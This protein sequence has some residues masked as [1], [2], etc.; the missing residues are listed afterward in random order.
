[1]PVHR[2]MPVVAPVERGGQFSW[3]CHIRIAVQ[4]VTEL[5]RIFLMNAGQGEIDEPL[6]RVD[7]E[8]G[9]GLKVLGTL[10]PHG[11]KKKN[12]KTKLFHSTDTV[13]IMLRHRTRLD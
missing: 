5:V 4:G 10:F 13:T 1:M 3:G 11:E 7:V 6:G 12:A 2:G 8:S 9:S